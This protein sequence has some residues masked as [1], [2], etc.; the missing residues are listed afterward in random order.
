MT[1]PLLAVRGLAVTFATPF[2]AVRGLDGAYFDVA[3]GEIVALVGESGSGKSV[4][5]LAVMGVLGAGGDGARASVEGR[6]IWDGGADLL[7]LPRGTRR[8]GLAMVFQEPMTALNP[9]L[10]VGR[11]IAEAVALHDGADAAAAAARCLVLLEQMGLPDPGRAA[12]AYPH[13]LSGGMRQRALIALAMACR[14]RLLIADEPTT[15]LDSTIQAKVLALLGGLSR[16][17]GLAMLLVTHDFG[18]VAAVA[19]R[20]A[21]MYGGR[22]VETGPVAALLAQPAHPY[23]RALLAAVPRLDL[24]RGVALPA[25]ELPGTPP[26]PRRPPPGCRFHPRCALARPGLCDAGPPPA[27][28]VLGPGRAAACHLLAA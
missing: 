21:V 7:R 16:E 26:D 22:V 19:D 23:T 20:V 3:S 1:A 4:A 6:A 14:P 25:E 9:V 17:H 12:R 28:R 15:A 11:Q 27:T 24:V 5:S 10:R 2:G 8:P 13:E 18:V